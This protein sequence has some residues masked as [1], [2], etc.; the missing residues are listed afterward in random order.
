MNSLSAIIIGLGMQ[1]SA[2][3]ACVKHDP[4]NENIAAEL[5]KFKRVQMTSA[6]A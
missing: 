6:T 3:P 5:A 1:V 2:Q 4:P